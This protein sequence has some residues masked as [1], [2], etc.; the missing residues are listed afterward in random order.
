MFL[1]R[2]LA[3]PGTPSPFVYLR[4]LVPLIIRQAPERIETIQGQVTDVDVVQWAEHSSETKADAH[5]RI[6]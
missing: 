3:L 1:L 6:L 2:V 4:H 5:A